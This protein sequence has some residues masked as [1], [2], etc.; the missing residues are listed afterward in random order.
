MMSATTRRGARPDMEGKMS[1][2]ELISG[3]TAY[4]NAAEIAADPDAGGAT[5]ITT[6]WTWI[7]TTVSMAV[8]A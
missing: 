2:A 7:T 4:T 8:D 6:T 3:Y 1:T 5:Q